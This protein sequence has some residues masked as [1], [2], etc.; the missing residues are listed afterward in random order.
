MN[1]AAKLAAGAL[2]GLC[3]AGPAAAGTLSI[4]HTVWVGYGPLYLARDLGYFKERGLTVELPSNAETNTSVAAQ[5]SGRLDGAAGTIDEL[6]QYRSP[7]FCF[8]SVF[9]LD[10]SFG[11]DGLVV[12]KSINSVAG[13]KGKTI[14]LNEGST[15]QYWL[16]YLLNREHLT[17]ADV[18][19]A[20]MSA[21]DAAAAFIAGRVPAAATWEPHLSFVR[22]HGVGKV[23]VDSSMTPRLIVDMVEFSCDVLKKRPDDIKALV[24]GYYKALAYIKSNP[25]EAYAI[26]AK[27][28]GGFLSKPEDI[29]EAMKGVRFYDKPMNIALYGTAAAPGPLSETISLG[30]QIWGAL[31]KIKKSISY[32]DVVD[33]SFV[34]E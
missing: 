20:T 16:N 1:S 14:A 27:G 15:S 23:L 6:L 2:F 11:G 26:M 7:E 19:I 30:N 13:L 22:T 4:G 21:D 33:T 29:A 3:I 32:D 10:E 9:A 25:T 34:A 17:Q 24:A 31:G 5:A 28:V 18:T 8:K 12:E